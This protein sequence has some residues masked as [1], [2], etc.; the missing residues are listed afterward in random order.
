MPACEPNDS[1]LSKQLIMLAALRGNRG[2][3][4]LLAELRHDLIE[5]HTIDLEF[6]LLVVEAHKSLDQCR[7]R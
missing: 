5:D 6:D 2:D 7:F 1:E 4:P 3:R